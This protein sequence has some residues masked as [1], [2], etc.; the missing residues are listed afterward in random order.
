MSRECLQYLVARIESEYG[1]PFF[2][3]TNIL[4]EMPV[5]FCTHPL[6]A[7]NPF[8]EQD[9]YEPAKQA[10]FAIP[11][12]QLMGSKAL[13]TL[14]GIFLGYE[15]QRE[16]KEYTRFVDQPDV[17]FSL[18]LS[19]NDKDMREGYKA[20]RFPLSLDPDNNDSRVVSLLRI[21]N[22]SNCSFFF[23]TCVNGLLNEGSG[24]IAV[25]P[26]VAYVPIR[27]FK[28]T[29]ETRC[30]AENYIYG[31]FA[32]YCAAFTRTTLESWGVESTYEGGVYSEHPVKHLAYFSPSLLQES[33]NG[34][35][36]AESWAAWMHTHAFASHKRVRFKPGFFF[37]SLPECVRAL[38]A[39][40]V[41][42]GEINEKTI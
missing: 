14:G 8:P 36:C 33:L 3:H 37:D 30:G 16:R 5:R 35:A 42:P 18:G 20:K 24:M 7:T 4:K 27:N 17:H 26:R 23:T 6:Y 9:L 39:S 15:V 31:T 19:V 13:S 21:A 22:R 28:N 38:L 25:S 32:D 2:A 12:D 29:V 41:A 1:I 40:Q 10:I 34:H 11:A